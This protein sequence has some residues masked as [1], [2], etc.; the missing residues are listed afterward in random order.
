MISTPIKPTHKA[1]QTYYEKL[2]G[3]G[4]HNVTNEMGLRSAFQQLLEETAKAHKW[5]LIPEQTL[6]VGGKSVR[7]DGTFRDEWH[8]RCGYWEAKDTSD[9]LNAEIRAKIAKG[10]PLVNTIFEDTRQA[11]L[12]QN[13]REAFRVPLSEP[14][15][16]ADLLN[17]FYAHAKPDIEGFK[18]AVDHFKEHIP[19]LARALDERIVDAHKTNS[20]FEVAFTD[21]FDLCRQSLNPNLRREAVDEMLVQ[22]LLTERLFRTVFDNADFTKRNVIAVEIERVIEALASQSFSRAEFLRKLDHFY[23]AI[24]DAAR[25]LEDWSEKQ[26]FLNTVYERFFQGYSVKVADTHGIVYTPQQIVDFM[27]A[28]VEHVL[29]T[30]FGLTLGDPGVNILDPCTGTGNFI[31]NLIRRIPKRDLP[32]V[33][34]EQLFANEVMLLPYYIAAMNIEHVY[35]EQ[36][37]TYEPFEGICFVDTLGL[38]EDEQKNLIFMS[39][40]NSARVE[41]QKKAEITVVIG[42]PPYNML[43][44]DENDDNRN[45]KYPIVDKRLSETFVRDSKATLRMQLYDPYVRF[46]R[47]AIDRLGDR[48]GIVCLVSNNSFVDQVAFDGMRRHLHREFRRVYHL[49]LRGNVR[50]NPTL[51]GTIYNVFGIQVGV[52]ITVAVRNRGLNESQL[53]YHTVP[54]TWR[55]GEKLAWLTQKRDVSDIEW[56]N[57]TPGA[58]HAWFG[59]QNSEEFDAF[60]P[61]GSKDAKSGKGMDAEAVFKIYGSGAKT[62]ADSYVYAFRRDDL[63]QRTKAM[64]EDFN[65]QLDRWKRSG[66]PS[67]LDGFLKVDETIH[68]WIRNTKRTLLRG[69]Y[70]AFDEAHIR[71]ALYRPFSKQH[72]FFDRFFN[73]DVYRLPIIFPSEKVSQENRAVCLTDVGSEKPFMTL[74]SD[75]IVDLHIVGAGASS[76]C[77]PFYVYDED[78]S[79]RRENITDW[80]LETFRDQYRNPEI[81]KWDIFYYVYGVL[82][83]PGY[84]TRFAD[85]LRREL[86]RIPL[87]DDF[88]AFAGAGKKLADLHQ[89][90]EI[91]EPW[92]LDWVENPDL[93]LSYRVEKMKLSKGKASLRVND[94]LTLASIPPEVLRY[95]LGNRSALEWVVDQYQVKPITGP[96]GDRVSDPNRPDNPEYIVRLVGQ[97]VRVSVETVKIIEALPPAFGW[98]EEPGDLDTT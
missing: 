32:R 25:G 27:C 22:H 68:K 44:Q 55:K 83:H 21:F 89:N 79:N 93:P 73:E 7:P 20:K 67:D 14:A 24:E 19:D 78:G 76:Q 33:Y 60:I 87:T 16:V 71:S 23:K 57:I 82:H 80:A 96:G 97:V 81:A 51:S 53:L 61:I 59:G 52:G 36:T 75:R 94:S 77:F 65:S 26:D 62:N 69:D 50:K 3:Y 10:Y 43:Q 92:P 46:F 34:R 2:Q 63:V 88:R 12:F 90:Y 17:A 39:E 74:I 56:N 54:E 98:P 47:W 85:N 86:P 18:Q 11:V 35:Y 1:I 31:V 5:T 66:R 13:G 70:A 91:L 45:R 41:R 49:D 95:R 84:R 42:N 40:A 9:D 72:H 29:K 64:V 6:K 4:A 58:R 28:S 8:L 30:E 48:D 38:A 15:K 37:G